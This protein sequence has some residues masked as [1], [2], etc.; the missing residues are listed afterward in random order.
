MIDIHCHLLPGIDDGPRND[1]EALAL[2]RALEANG[3]TFVVCTPHIYP[4]V[5]DNTRA[6]I[7]EKF[8]HV[9]K[10]VRDA[11]LPL[12]LSFGSEVRLSPE[13]LLW[14]RRGDLPM[15][16]EERGGKSLLVEMPD[17]QV[18]LGTDKLIY[19]LVREGIQPIVVH[20]ERNKQIMSKPALV[21]RLIDA[22]AKLQVTAGSVVGSFGGPAQKAAEIMLKHDWVSVIASDSHNIKGRAPKMRQAGEWI[23]ERFGA[24]RV[25]RLF[26]DEPKR[27][28][29]LPV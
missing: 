15:L 20:P 11:C 25:H 10:L 21:Q 19:Q 1:E 3:V 24:D 13:L 5:F 16:V 29:C 22:G 17:N 12:Q 26:V 2:A 23:E 8:K 4:G 9:V 6:G 14:T 27:L 18:P 7:A 28:C